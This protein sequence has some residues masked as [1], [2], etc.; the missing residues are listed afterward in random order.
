MANRTSTTTV[1]AGVRGSRLCTVCRIADGHRHTPVQDHHY[2]DGIAC[3][4]GCHDEQSERVVLD[5]QQWVSF[6]LVSLFLTAALRER[7]PPTGTAP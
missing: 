2:A 3:M 5:A 6:L 1:E 4:C 7:G